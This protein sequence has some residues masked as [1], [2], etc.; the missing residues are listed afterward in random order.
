MKRLGVLAAAVAAAA[1]LALLG[2]G[3]APAQEL[4]ANCSLFTGKTPLWLDFADGSV[5]FWRLF[6]RPG[7]VATA[8]NLQLPALIRARGGTT[9]YFDLHLKE[10]VGVPN[11]PADPATLAGAGLLFAA[12]ALLACW[13][14][15]RRAARVNPLEALR[16][17]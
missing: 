17:E 8:P 13:V 6:A 2:S 16:C 7:V 3:R 4:Q 11:A 5:P 10:R 1:A 14:P 9:V 12:V 15:T